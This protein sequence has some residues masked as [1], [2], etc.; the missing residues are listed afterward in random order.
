MACNWRVATV[1][2]LH[3]VDTQRNRTV[4]T[5]LSRVP[6][7]VDTQH[8]R[9]RAKRLWHVLRDLGT[10]VVGVVGMVAMVAGIER[11]AGQTMW[12]PLRCASLQ[13]GLGH[14]MQQEQ[15]REHLAG[16]ADKYRSALT[17]DLLYLWQHIHKHVLKP[18][19][20][21]AGVALTRRGAQRNDLVGTNWAEYGWRW[22]HNLTRTD[23]HTTP[24]SLFLACPQA[25]L[26]IA[27]NV[28]V[29]ADDRAISCT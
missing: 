4:G 11:R 17:H 5:V 3:V 21:G 16:L 27:R 23:M 28:P 22:P 2:P 25:P 8:G 24:A 15:T 20:V 12:K 10:W 29:P 9:K 1:P 6:D 19:I 18:G 14:S 13:L 7:R 26:R